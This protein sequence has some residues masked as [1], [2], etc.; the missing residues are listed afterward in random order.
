[1]AFALA[2]ELRSRGDTCVVV[3]AAGSYRQEAGVPT[4]VDPTSPADYTRLLAELGAGTTPPLTGA[5]HLF[6]LDE[7]L[8][9]DSSARQL[10]LSQQRCCGS[11][12]QLARALA[13]TEGVS[14]GL[15]LVTRGAQ[16]ISEDDAGPGLAQSTVRGL[17]RSIAAEHP[18]LLCRAIDLDP[19]GEIESD[20]KLVRDELLA[21][22]DD[23]EVVLRG[24][25]RRVPRLVRRGASAD[26]H[27]PRTSIGVDPFTLAAGKSA[28]LDGLHVEKIDL[29]P[30]R[31]GEVRLRVLATGLN[32]RDTLTALG[33]YPGDPGPLGL[34]AAGIVTALGDG[35]EGLSVGDEVV[36]VGF[37][38]F[39]SHMT[40]SAELVVPKPPSLSFAE[41]A[42]IPIVFLTAH[43]AFHEL[44]RLQ[45][46]QRVLIHAAAGGVGLAAVQLATAAGAELFATAGNP[47]KRAHVAATGVRHVADSRSLA[48]ADSIRRLAPDGIDVVLNS[49]SGESIPAS[50]S[51]LRQGGCFIEMG[52]R[53]TWDAARVARERPDVEF[54][55]F[56]LAQLIAD[57]P[58][59]LRPMLIDVMAGIREGRLQPLPVRAFPIENARGAFRYM[60]QAR[61]IG[62]IAVEQARAPEAFSPHGCYLLT[63]G[64][65]GL[66]FETA[67]WL[68][69]RGAR[70][71]VL[72]SRSEATEAAQAAVR[73]LERGGATVRT[74]RCDVA[75]EAQVQRLLGEIRKQGPL[76]GVF[77]LAGAL[78]DGALLGQTWER[79]DKVFRPKVLGAWNLHRYTR[80]DTLDCFVLFSSWASLLGSPGQT[81]YSAANAFLDAL[82]HH[83]RA[84]GLAALSINWG[85][86]AEVGLASQGDRRRQLAGRGIGSFTPRQ[87]LEALGRLMGQSLPQLAATPFD[88]ARWLESRSPRLS[89]IVELLPS[90]SSGERNDETEISLRERMLAAD[91]ARARRELMEKHVF[92]ELARKL[93]VP[94]A[95][96]DARKSFKS[97]GLDSL[98]ALELRNSLELATELTLSATVVWNY[99]TVAQLAEHLAEQMDVEPQAA[100]PVETELEGPAEPSL[101]ALVGEL[102]SLSDEEVRRILEEAAQETAAHE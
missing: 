46:G 67:R 43:Y 5:I 44:A 22:S 14:P 56:D 25:T 47:R 32:F 21:G 86:W 24:G 85:A 84:R 94:A 69:E 71:L 13:A 78:D 72:A 77:H 91:S 39:A 100:R 33:L 1:V 59:R 80:A 90:A 61:Q 18:E 29:D 16:P 7:E 102:E 37:A 36:A 101:D 70:R 57:E 40:A 19:A 96:V 76:R 11:A 23:G 83:R 75:D 92:D 51:L 41:A 45:A 87:G 64:L 52:K 10:A 30:P 95:Q 60:Q 38:A 48:F 9:D 42:G 15:T 81:N 6:S 3:A 2:A 31:R 20:G 58:Q 99:P 55:H 27:E 54:A 53:G 66:G 35:V 49:L 98:T 88:A 82:A 4:G 73:D 79:F 63:G 89:A 68:V 62:K 28:G 8:A 26:P 34:E 93:R 17:A 65:G 97:L 74:V 50:L 12:M